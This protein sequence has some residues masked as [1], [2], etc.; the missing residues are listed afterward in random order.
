MLG[1]RSLKL[2]RVFGIRIGVDPSWFLVLFLI[3]WSLSNAYGDTYPGEDGKAFALATVS[4]LLFFLSVVLHELGHAVVAVRNGIG[5]SGIDLWLFGGVAKM[6]R[7][8]D[9]AGVELRVA[10]AGP[11]VTLAIVVACAG[12][13]MLVAGA[14]DFGE[15]SFFEA[16]PRA[17]AAEVVLGYLASVNALLL[18]FNLLPGFPLD[19]GRIVRAVAWWRTGD[20]ARATRFAAAGG[21]GLSYVL[22]G[23]GIFLLVQGLV[24][25]GVSLVFI[26]LFLGRAARFAE[27][28]SRVSARI[29]GLRVAD[30]MDAQPV[31]VSDR[32]RLDDALEDFFLRYRWP[33]FPVVDA[34]GRFVGLLSRGEVEAVP[35]PMRPERTVDEVMTPD[36]AGS[37]RVSTDERLESVLDS[38]TD[39]LRRLGAVMA[40]DGEGV[41]RGVVTLER[42]R[43]AL[44]PATPAV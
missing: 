7:D 28:Q 37:L 16:A 8:T 41:L 4:A 27:L 20:R 22:V 30:V 12:A 39:G 5:I 32:T 19:G 35:E 1:G 43:R 10:I 25:T 40:V 13:G 33:W 17:S 15:A 36:T 18:V 9:S 6:T 24:L 3:I 11:L 29:E 21:R 2:A 23:L 38:H 26:G 44:R 14:D 42:V 34:A 31:A